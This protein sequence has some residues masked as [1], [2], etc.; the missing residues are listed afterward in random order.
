MNLPLRSY[1]VTH[2]ITLLFVSLIVC[3]MSFFLY[4]NVPSSMHNLLNVLFLV[5]LLIKKAF[6]VMILTFIGFSPLE[7]LS[8]KIFF[9]ATQYD[10][11]HFPI[12]ILPLDIIPLEFHGPPQDNSLAIA[13][14][15][16][17]EST[18]I[19]RSSHIHEPL[20]SYINSLIAKLSFIPIASSYK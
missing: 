20:E 13:L 18:S 12:S 10:S 6:Y 3:I 16:E 17:P 5:T 19:C 11:L 4:K 14:V 8:S 9:F 15:Q 2:L 1:L 7:M